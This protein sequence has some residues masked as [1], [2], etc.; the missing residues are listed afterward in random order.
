MKRK[1]ISKNGTDNWK[2]L[3]DRWDYSHVLRAVLSLIVLVAL[4]V[5]IAI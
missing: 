2:T 5:A 1:G 3:R 4:I